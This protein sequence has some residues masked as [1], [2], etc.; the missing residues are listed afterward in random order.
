MRAVSEANLDWEGKLKPTPMHGTASI[1]DTPYAAR[2]Q[3]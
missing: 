1:R 3:Q 2:Y